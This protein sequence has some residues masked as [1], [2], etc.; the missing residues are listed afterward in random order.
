MMP[1][2]KQLFEK[3]K[4]NNAVIRAEFVAGN[5]SVAF[6]GRVLSHSST[7]LCLSRFDDEMSVSLF[8]AK[9]DYFDEVEG[10]PE[11]Q[12]F[13]RRNY[14][15]AVRVVTDAGVTCMVYEVRNPML[16]RAAC[17]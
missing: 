16:K 6:T 9:L 11:A 2:Y 13:F 7:E 15:C 17:G 10:S 4:Q 1:E 12:D 5:I 3:W 14:F 8:C